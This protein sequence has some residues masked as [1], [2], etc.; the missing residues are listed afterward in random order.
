MTDIIAIDDPDDPRIAPYRDVRERDLVGRKGLFVA[1]GEVVL[2]V[3]FGGRA[4]HRPLSLLIAEK[5]VSR[6]AGLLAKVPEGVPVYAAAQP[7]IDAI[8]GFHI[9]RGILAIGKRAPM[10]S[11]RGAAFRSWQPRAWWWCFRASPITTIWAASAATPPPSAP[12]PCSSIRDCCDPFY[13]KAIRVSVGAA[14]TLP[15]A[16]VATAE[17][18]LDLL[19]AH[20]FQTLAL[21]PA[22]EV[23]ARRCQ[24]SRA[25]RRALRRG[26][27]RAQAGGDRPR[28]ERAHRHG[29]RHGF[30]QCRH[31]QRHR[32]ASP[33]LWHALILR[34]RPQAAPEGWAVRAGHPSLNVAIPKVRL[35]DTCARSR[36]AGRIGRM[37]SALTGRLK[38]SGCRPPWR[39]GG[40]ASR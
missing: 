38:A 12:M 17:A 35:S 6:L 11:R 31:R 15:F 34:R 13:R 2:N 25:R 36:S 9:H 33:G 32:A 4:L 18:A 30:A 1:E 14:L 26:R 21:S 40:E 37:A 39:C 8:T 10:P 16:R 19:S 28:H 23:V 24:A 7:I 5:R 29:G 22:G 3:L 27:A 20:G